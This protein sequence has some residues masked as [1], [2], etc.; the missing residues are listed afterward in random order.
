MIIVDLICRQIPV[1]H[2]S[3]EATEANNQ[4]LF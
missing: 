4:V 1:F 2:F 3:T